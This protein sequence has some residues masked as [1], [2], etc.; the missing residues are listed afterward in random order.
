MVLVPIS[1][2]AGGCASGPPTPAAGRGTL[3][4]QVHLVRREGVLPTG[5][6]T[7]GYADPR[8]RDVAFV[9]YDRPGFVVVFVEG[10]TATRDPVTLQLE[11]TRFGPRLK[12]RN[13]AIE[14]GQSIVVENQDTR[15]H[16]IS[17][18]EENLLQSVDP[19]AQL[20]LTPSAPG[21][22]N[23]FLLDAP[24]EEVLV[25]IANG[26]L[27]ITTAH[28]VWELRNLPPGPTVL[29][30]W[31]PRFPSASQEVEVAA[32]AVTRV[33]LEISVRNLGTNQDSYREEP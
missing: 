5:R 18:T 12:P 10:E 20:T 2:L 9:D 14:L 23:L 16:T 29:R 4:G 33:E 3:W 30:A 8:M 17:C 32:D 21:P 7:P 31:H 19:G 24:G 13:A 1:F 11:H 26:P 28:G 6:S 27:A 15:P 22:L 25:F